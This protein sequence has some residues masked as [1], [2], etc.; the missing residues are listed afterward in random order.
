MHS[1]ADGHLGTLYLLATVSSAAINTG[2]QLSLQN[3]DFISF[4]YI[5][6]GGIPGL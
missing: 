5:P 4:G 6:S 1:S 3:T 2:V